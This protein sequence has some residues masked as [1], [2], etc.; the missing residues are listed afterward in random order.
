MGIVAIGTGWYRY[1]LYTHDFSLRVLGI[2]DNFQGGR[3]STDFDSRLY[4]A[5]VGL[6]TCNR[7]LQRNQRAIQFDRCMSPFPIFQCSLSFMPYP[8]LCL[9]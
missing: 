2:R 4:A 9:R 5:E 8:P 6:E 7:L 3:L 1:V